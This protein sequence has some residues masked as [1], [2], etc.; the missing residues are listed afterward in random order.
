MAGDFCLDNIMDTFKRIA[1]IV[2]MLLCSA[3]MWNAKAQNY[4]EVK[5]G[6]V[7][8]VTY[9]GSEV[10]S[11]T[12]TQDGMVKIAGATPDDYF[13][14]CLDVFADAGFQNRIDEFT[15]APAHYEFNAKAGHTY[16]IKNN[17]WTQDINAMLTMAG[18]FAFTG[19]HPAEGAGFYV[20]GDTE[21]KL[22]FSSSNVT[23]S[24]GEMVC[25]GNE[26][27]IYNFTDWNQ[28]VKD[29]VITYYQEG[30]NG[31][32][33]YNGN[34]LGH[35]DTE[36]IT[37]PFI[38]NTGR[39]YRNL[40]MELMESGSISQGMTMTLT[41]HGVKNAI[42]GEMLNG[43]GE[44][45]VTWTVG[46]MPTKLQ[47][48]SVPSTI[49]SWYP[50][51][52]PQAVARFTFSREIGSAKAILKMGKADDD[53]TDIYTEE[54]DVDIDGNTVTVDLSGVERTYSS[55]GLTQSWES[56]TLSLLQVVDINGNAA[57]SGGEQ[58]TVATYSYGARYV[59]VETGDDSE[60]E[61]DGI[62]PADL[63]GDG[64]VSVLDYNM[65][66]RL[67]LTNTLY[68]PSIPRHKAGD[69]N[70]DKRLDVADI[71][72]LINILIH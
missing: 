50:K 46:G 70:G 66:L 26:I 51:G 41:L 18:A 20:S 54:L 68:D 72:A 48:A 53:I 56:F 37:I 24:T 38:S 67:I 64:R 7:F 42:T 36:G 60:D 61:D 11:F 62:M 30:L 29:G 25:N 14:P 2:T 6:Q 23:F 47:T 10:W 59:V 5:L 32:A 19:S 69:V 9:M 34:V 28:L 44:L 21:A 55:M 31:V 16:Y 13:G 65:L 39:G 4:A 35:A 15:Y 49:K 8:V 43:D 3:T 52:D 58:G 12:A 33:D 1:I 22:Y 63:S 40:I 45:K 57:Y 71:S 17:N 27:K